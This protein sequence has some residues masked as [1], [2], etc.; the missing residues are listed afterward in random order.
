MDDVIRDLQT[1]Q[2]GLQ[3]VDVIDKLTERLEEMDQYLNSFGDAIDDADKE[4]AK[5]LKEQVISRMRE[6]RQALE[7]VAKEGEEA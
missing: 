2:I 5:R 4:V 7:K 3:N 6:C 1:V